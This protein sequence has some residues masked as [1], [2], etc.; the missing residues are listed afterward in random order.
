MNSIGTKTKKLGIAALSL[1]LGFAVNAKANETDIPIDS[2]INDLNKVKELINN[3]E[4]SADQNEY[5][6]RIDSIKNMLDKMTLQ[7]KLKLM[8]GPNKC[9]DSLRPTGEK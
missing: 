6:N 3:L 1:A 7:E 2:K 4:L 9:S 8:R 5:Q